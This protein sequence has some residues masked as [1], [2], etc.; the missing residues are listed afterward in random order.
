MSVGPPA[1]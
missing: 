1:V